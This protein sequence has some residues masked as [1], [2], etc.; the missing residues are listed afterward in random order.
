M[1]SINICDWITITCICIYDQTGPGANTNQCQL[2]QI[3]E[4]KIE[5]K[6][7]ELINCGFRKHNITNELN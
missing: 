1:K 7:K 6:E 5:Q 3:Y 2:E 4:K